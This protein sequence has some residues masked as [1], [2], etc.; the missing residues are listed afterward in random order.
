MRRRIRPSAED[1][2]PRV[3]LSVTSLVPRDATPPADDTSDSP[4]ATL[5]EATTTDTDRT[6]T[7][8]VADPV[9]SGSSSD[10]VDADAQSDVPDV[11]QNAGTDQPVDS[12]SQSR[13]VKRDQ[14]NEITQDQTA[15]VVAREIT[16]NVI[17][18]V[19]DA[20]VTRADVGVSE[21]ERTRI[22]SSDSG[23]NAIDAELDDVID[24][25][26][27]T[28]DSGIETEDAS[29]AAR[30]HDVVEFGDVQSSDSVVQVT[31]EGGVVAEPTQIA[32]DGSELSFLEVV[33]DERAEAANSDEFSNVAATGWLSA[34]QE[35][36]LSW[37]GATTDGDEAQ[38]EPLAEQAV[39]A[40][41]VAGVF[42]LM[43]F[44]RKGLGDAD[45]LPAALRGLLDLRDWRPSRISNRRRQ[46]SL[47]GQSTGRKEAVASASANLD[48]PELSD[49]FLMSV[50]VPVNPQS[51]AMSSIPADGEGSNDD[52]F[53][54]TATTAVVAVTAAAGGWAAR[55]NSTGG[56]QQQ[57][58]PQIEFGGTTF[59]RPRQDV[60]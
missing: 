55:R 32:E 35:S 50:A 38:A 30:K 47:P 29:V 21:A 4:D 7:E 46:K 59:T 51:F 44:G 10:L 31:D 49:A 12:V 24:F 58:R 8:P 54:M 41:G 42:S 9:D 26:D 19:D 53:D 40:A 28:D 57:P 6:A 37:F 15:V 45:R 25:R 18:S 22:A 3:V 34:L 14:L 43:A 11:G 39:S 33:A 2:E 1:L 52:D 60:G 27:T 20:G 13:P 36:L 56:K 5:D 23:G 48:E 17:D 16:V